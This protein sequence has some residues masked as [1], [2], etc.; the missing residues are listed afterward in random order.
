MVYVKEAME[1]NLGYVNFANLL[2]KKLLEQKIHEIITE[3]RELFERR[4][5][6]KSENNI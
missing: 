2:S 3:T 6:L 1:R 5:Q 4:E